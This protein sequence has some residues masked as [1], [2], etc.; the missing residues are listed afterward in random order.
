MEAK[1]FFDPPE[2][3]RPQL[4]VSACYLHHR[5]QYLFLRNAPSKDYAGCWGLPGGKIEEN[6]STLQG[7][8]RE[9]LEETGIDLLESRVNHLGHVYM[10]TM[11][12]FTFHMYFYDLDHKPDIS[13]SKLEH[14]KSGWFTKDQVFELPLITGGEKLLKYFY[15]KLNFF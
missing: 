12:D 1:V 14:E 6:E 10:R 5:G 13:L 11:V 3:F 8:I 7:M 2:D 9:V 15:K 4:D